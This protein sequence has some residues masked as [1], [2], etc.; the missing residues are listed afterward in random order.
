MSNVPGT[1]LSVAGANMMPVVNLQEISSQLN[2][3]TIPESYFKNLTF[4]DLEEVG[5]ARMEESLNNIYLDTYSILTQDDKTNVVQSLLRIAFN[6]AIADTNDYD[7]LL[8]D[9]SVSVN[10]NADIK[11]AIIS[12]IFYILNSSYFKDS[13]KMVVSNANERMQ[14]FCKMCKQTNN[15]QVMVGGVL[16]ILAGVGVVLALIG[17][18]VFTDRQNKHAEKMVELETGRLREEQAPL[19]AG[20]AER[21]AQQNFLM[22]VHQGQQYQMQRL[23][24]ELQ[25]EKEKRAKAE[26]NAERAKAEAQQAMLAGIPRKE[27]LRIQSNFA[28][29]RGN[30]GGRGAV[31][32]NANVVRALPRLTRAEQNA[33]GMFSGKLLKKCLNALQDGTY[34]EFMDQYEAFVEYQVQARGYGNGGKVQGKLSAGQGRA[35]IGGPGQGKL[36][37]GK[38]QGKRGGYRK[39]RS[40]KLS[41]TNRSTR[42][43]V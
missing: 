40:V 11:K 8:L 6:L 22:Q 7:G 43:R 17:G 13:F 42:K 18:A 41:K 36:I 28:N 14:D 33:C 12:T 16:P 10:K 38:K 3:Q 39:S 26:A 35:Q 37:P 9:D 30:S 34:I 2:L 1:N 19:M 32:S 21:A 29:T 27:Q 25:V 4:T 15:T 31:V 23:D 24:L 5:D 20:Y